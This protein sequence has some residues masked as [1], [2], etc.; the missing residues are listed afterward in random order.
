MGGPG[1]VSTALC[2]NGTKL[3]GFRMGDGPTRKEPP[4]KVRMVGGFGRVFRAS[5]RALPVEYCH[6]DRPGAEG[7]FRDEKV[8]ARP[9]FENLAHLRSTM[10][11]VPLKKEL[12]HERNT[13]CGG[14]HW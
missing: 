3:S 2:W 13:R 5:S 4:E 6:S 8:T 7:E 1:A 14:G 12:Y 9:R 10:P 11:L